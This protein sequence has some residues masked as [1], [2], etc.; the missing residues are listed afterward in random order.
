MQQR[1]MQCAHHRQH[2]G[3]EFHTILGK[4]RHNVGDLARLRG[5][6]CLQR[7]SLIKPIIMARIAQCDS[8]RVTRSMNSGMLL[9]MRDTCKL[10]TR[11]LICFA[12]AGIKL[13]GKYLQLHRNFY[14]ARLQNKLQYTG[15]P[16]LS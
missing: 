8:V 16:K 3:S 9:H 10:F 13:I 4:P 11:S 15:T 5:D 6:N 7:L 1:H 12:G 2:F 14:N